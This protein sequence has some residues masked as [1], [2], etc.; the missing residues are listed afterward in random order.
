[1][2]HVELSS[3]VR[4]RDNDGIRLL[5]GV[6]FCM[7]VVAV[8]PKLIGSVLDLFGIVDLFQLLAH[9]SFPPI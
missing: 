3:N 4:R 9:V 7:E 8:H 5:F 6:H 1:M 2:S